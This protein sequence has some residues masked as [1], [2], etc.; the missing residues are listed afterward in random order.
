MPLTNSSTCKTHSSARTFTK[1]FRNTTKTREKLGR[2]ACDAS[3]G[4]L[5]GDVLD[6]STLIVPMVGVHSLMIATVGPLVCP[7]MTGGSKYYCPCGDFPI[8]VDFNGGKLDAP[9]EASHRFWHVVFISSMGATVPRQVSLLRS[10]LETDIMLS[11]LTYVIVKPCGWPMAEGGQKELMVGHEDMMAVM[12]NSIAWADVASLCV[13]WL[14]RA[15]AC[16][17]TCAPRLVCRHQIMRSAHRNAVF[18]AVRCT[19]VREK[20]WHFFVEL[21]AVIKGIFTITAPPK[22]RARCKEGSGG[23]SSTQ[24]AL[25]LAAVGQDRTAP[26]QSFLV[27]AR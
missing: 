2:I 19:E 24:G 8:D 4:N 26:P 25:Y 17:L 6:P 18:R 11:G 3:E 22:H 9:A 13:W 14:S 12:P 27:F 1:L 20:L 5:I 23:A 16:A 10:N 15:Q 7:D 21:C